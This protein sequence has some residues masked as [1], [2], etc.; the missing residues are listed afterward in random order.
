[1]P[2]HRIG[3]SRALPPLDVAALWQIKRIGNPTLSPDGR[4]AC[5]SVT[6]FAMDTNES[7]TELWLFPT[8]L[9]DLDAAGKGVAAI[10]RPRRLTAGDKDSEPR[11]S[12]DGK[13]IAFTAKRKDDSEAQV[14]RIAPDGGE[15]ERDTK[16]A[17]GASAVKWFPDSRRIAFVSSVW[18]QLKS[19]AAQGR[20]L[21]DRRD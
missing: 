10:T 13:W 5:A 6:S 14:Y 19:D 17:T 12:P 1:M 16:I 4:V 21:K 3:R 9:A 20:R 2:P 18:P 8:G 7:K 11:W 15:A